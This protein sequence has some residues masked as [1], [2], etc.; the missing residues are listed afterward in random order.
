MRTIGSA[1]EDAG[2]VTVER[3]IGLLA[4]RA[5]CRVAEAHRHL[6]RMAAERRCDVT[7]LAHRVIRLLDSP[8]AVADTLPPPETVPQLVTAAMMNPATIGA[9]ASRPAVAGPATG[10][11]AV[12][13]LVADG[14]AAGDPAWGAVPREPGMGEAAPW[15]VT[16]Q[17]VL[18]T[19]PGMCAYLLAEVDDQGRMTDLIWAAAS[20]EAVAPDGRRG[21]HLIGLPVSRHHPEATAGDRRR[22]YQRVLDTGEPADI[23]PIRMGGSDFMIRAARLGPGLLISWERRRHPGRL[24]GMEQLGNLGWGSGIWSAARSTGHPSCTGSTSGIR[25]WAR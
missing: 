10:G 9:A 14:P 2:R 8:E 20:P 6:L 16:V 13:G 17:N 1:G 22:I 19:L 11:P 7:E 25:R 15:L 3:A 18:D 23:G 21:T 12:A 24:D 5:R 4:G